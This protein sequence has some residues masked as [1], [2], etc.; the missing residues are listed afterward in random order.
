MGRYEI[1]TGKKKPE[2]RIE[3]VKTFGFD[4]DLTNDMKRTFRP[5]MR[6]GY[7]DL[8]DRQIARVGIVYTDKAALFTGSN[9]HFN[10]IYF[11]C[12]SGTNYRAPCCDYSRPLFRTACVLVKYGYGIDQT[13]SLED[14]VYELKPWVFGPSTYKK[15]REVHNRTPLFDHDIILSRNNPTLKIYD[16]QPS[17]KS[18]W[19]NVSDFIEQKILTESVPLLENMKNAIG[20]DLSVSEINELIEAAKGSRANQWAIRFNDMPPGNYHA[21]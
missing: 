17:G 16:I 4:S 9:T 2:P 8:Q 11:L 19:Q 10:G 12:K 5:S 21:I 15:L 7:F 1:A 3:P 20:S 6:H 14:F 13:S 18:L